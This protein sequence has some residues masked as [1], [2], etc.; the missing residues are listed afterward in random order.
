[1]VA[2]G[3]TIVV[4][5]LMFIVRPL[6]GGHRQVRPSDD[7]NFTF[8]YFVCLFLTA[9]VMAIMLVEDLVDN[10]SETITTTF[11]LILL[12]VLLVPIV[13]PVFLTYYSNDP[14]PAKES[15]LNEHEKE[16]RGESRQQTEVILSEVEDE[17][18]KE[19]D[20]LPELERQK[21]NCT[22]AGEAFPGCSGR[23]CKSQKEKRSSQRRGLHLVASIG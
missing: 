14:M 10:L 22:V 17:K 9:Y 21:R 23:N 3:P 20:S 13:I 18:P 19:V 11:T 15:L 8:I 6:V 4:I 7:H 1:M 2:V 12:F 16:E 5:A